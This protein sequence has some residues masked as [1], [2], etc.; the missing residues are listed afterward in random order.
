MAHQDRQEKK[1]RRGRRA[2]TDGTRR[3]PPTPSVWEEFLPE[4]RHL[5]FPPR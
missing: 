2:P 5:L 3:L 4:S 1:K